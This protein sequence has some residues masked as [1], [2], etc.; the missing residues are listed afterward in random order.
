MIPCEGC[1]I[2]PVCRRKDYM[3]LLLEC[4]LIETALYC[5][6]STGFRVRRKSYRADIFKLYEILKP[7]IWTIPT[8]KAMAVTTKE[9][10]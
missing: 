1:L 6:S 7:T 10:K 2:L 8:I 3:K 4:R 5:K 9:D